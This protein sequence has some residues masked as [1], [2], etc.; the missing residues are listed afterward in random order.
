MIPHSLNIHLPVWY[1]V[2]SIKEFMSYINEIN[3]SF[4]FL[5]FNPRGNQVQQI[6]QIV[7]AMLDDN[8]RH[9]ILSAPTGTGKSLIGAV[10]GETVHRIKKPNQQEG[11]TFLLSATNVLLHQYMETF[12]PVNK[13]DRTNFCL[14]KGASN[15]SC[16][17]LS[18]DTEPQTAESCSM[19]LFKL[20]GMD[21]IISKYCSSCEFQ[22]NRA[23]RD[24]SRHL[25][26]NY[27]YY[28]TDRL[29]AQKFMPR[30]VCV[31]DEAHLINDLYTEHCAIH[32][33]EKRLLVI[34]QEVSDNLK[35]GNAQIFKD[36]KTIG[37]HLSSGK[38]MGETYR[39]YIAILAEIYTDIYEAASNEAERSIRTPA[40]YLKL[41]KMAMKYIGL[42]NKILDFLEHEYAHSFEYKEKDTKTG[43]GDHEVFIKPIFVSEKFE[44]LVN[45]DHNLIMSATISERFA[46]RTLTLDPK[47]RVQYIKLDPQFP[48]ENKKV[49]F[50]NAANLNYNTM[51]DPEVVKKLSNNAA[52]IAKHHTDKGER[53]IVL[54]PSFV[55]VESIA[56]VLRRTLGKDVK[57]FEH[58]RGEKLADWI[59]AFKAY[60]KGPAVFLTPSGFEGLD[61]AGDLSR[62]QIISKV[63]F[64]SLGDKRI[65]YIADAF[66]DIYGEL[67]LMKIVQGA[68]R[69]VRSADDYA[70]TYILDAAGARLWKNNPWADEFESSFKTNL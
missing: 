56:G 38:I 4:D 5:G 14:L 37:T 23:M 1:N 8:A 7:R 33:S 63:P 58:L 24:K 45:A 47:E 53:G 68:G 30:T 44:T 2:R 20:N 65:K 36:L 13:K 60:D 54:A 21:D 27:S 34:A 52:I 61:L 42:Q 22:Q 15:Y 26:T 16:E 32:F 41:N 43:Q 18:S 12:E 29:S 11:A 59:Q 19:I 31:F 28:F 67:A 48:K 6:D 69:S 25:I 70:T 51:K 9:V 50:F 17:A 39:D 64:G 62:F 40:K 3:E 57:I 55:L 49:I 35:L 10:V 46:K 66:P